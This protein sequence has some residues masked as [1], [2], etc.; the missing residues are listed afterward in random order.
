MM[1]AGANI[2]KPENNKN[3]SDTTDGEEEEKKCTD[4]DFFSLHFNSFVYISDQNAHRFHGVS[5]T[6]EFISEINPPPPKG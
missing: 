1:Q 4:D 6:Q 2:D 3:A 5:D